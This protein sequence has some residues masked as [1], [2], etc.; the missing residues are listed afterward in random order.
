MALEGDPFNF[1]VPSDKEGPALF[2]T[3]APF[4]NAIG[5]PTVAPSGLGG[6]PP[7]CAATEVLYVLRMCDSWGDGW[8]NTSMVITEIVP[9]MESSELTTTSR[10][11]VD[12]LSQT[13]YMEEGAGD[14]IFEDSLEDGYNDYRY[15]C[16]QVGMCYNIEVDGDGDWQDEIKWD[17]TDA[18]ACTGSAKACYEDSAET[19]VAKGLAPAECVFSV[20]DEGGIFQCPFSCKVYTEA[21][22]SSPSAMPS[23]APSL[24]PSS[25]AFPTSSASPTSS[26]LP[27]GSA[28]PTSMLNEIPVFPR[29]PA[30]A[31][32]V[33][34]L[35]SDMPSL[36]PSNMPS[37]APSDSGQASLVFIQSDAPSSVP[38][39]ATT[40]D[41]GSNP[42]TVEASIVSY[43]YEVGQLVWAPWMG[44]E[45]IYVGEIAAVKTDETDGSKTYDVLFDDGEFETDL[46]PEDL[47]PIDLTETELVSRPPITVGLQVE[48]RYLGEPFW[49]G[50]VV[51][52]IQDDGTCD[53]LYDDG[54]EEFGVL[55]Q[56]IRWEYFTE[57]ATTPD[58][59]LPLESFT[60]HLN[61]IETPTHEPSASPSGFPGKHCS[62][63]PKSVPSAVASMPH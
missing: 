59:D 39:I 13:T 40:S 2:P 58:N 61:D 9:T 42:P 34:S 17:I 55:P 14:T 45:E 44:S 8:G 5:T 48:A 19:T 53:I 60:D 52:A 7:E 20:P 33:T 1:T 35:P 22:S 32:N 43:P 4:S 3:S 25:T 26:A 21:P 24:V 27:T 41:S 57:N 6:G 30:E 15:L 62:S 36:A 23:D 28:T 38:S 54:D 18:S 47:F 37:G 50:G 46:E 29:N 63:E 12:S 10:Y 31:S 49:F 11:Y 16:L 51:V 56:Y